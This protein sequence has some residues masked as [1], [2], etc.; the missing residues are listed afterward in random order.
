MYYVIEKNNS[1]A[2]H[3][4]CYTKERAELWISEKAPEYC[5]KGYFMDKTL[6]FD[7]FTIK[8]GK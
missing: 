4:H 1:L 7:S 8:E 3:S 6:T 2:V 5:A